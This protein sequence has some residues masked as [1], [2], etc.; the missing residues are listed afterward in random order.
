MKYLN[1][2]KIIALSAVVCLTSY[3][4]QASDILN[5]VT[6]FPQDA[7]ITKYVGGS[8]VNVKSLAK[9]SYDPHAIQPKPSLALML[10]KADLLITN[11]QDM[12]LAWLPIALSNS[13]NPKILDGEDGN[14]DPSEGV[15]LIP[16]TKDELVNTPFFSL[17]LM[18]GTQKS[19]GGQVNL[20][21]GNHHYWLD[22][23]NGIVVARN[24]ANKLAEMDPENAAE[25][26]NNANKFSN[27]LKE[28][29]K[30]WDSQMQP[31]KGT[32]VV[33]YHRDWIYLIKRHNLS[34]FGYVE[35]RETI[36]PSAGELAALAIKMKKNKVNVIITSPWQNQRISN[37]LSKITGAE[38]LTLPSS[39]G[40]DVGVKDYIN[41]FEIIYSRL[42]PALK[43]AN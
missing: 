6:S 33:S 20:T 42:I 28:K 9:A 30:V 8:H 10:N 22:P 31:F 21:R 35:P 13:R 11:G 17:N 2:I 37:E 4:T 41:M 29:M 39:V 23:E 7:S 40:T 14:L 38:H 24:I 19:G 12:E 25:Y 18:A 26:R 15:E 34:L 5:V 27:T 32:K 36:P 1:K 3:P 43:K 16:Y